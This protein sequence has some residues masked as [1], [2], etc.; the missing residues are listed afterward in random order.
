MECDGHP[1]I[2]LVCAFNPYSN[3]PLLKMTKDDCLKVLREKGGFRYPKK[4]LLQHSEWILIGVGHWG[5]HGYGLY[6]RSKEGEGG[7]EIGKPFMK[8]TLSTPDP[9]SKPNFSVPG[10]PVQHESVMLDH[11]TTDLELLAYAQVVD[12]LRAQG[13]L[14][15]HKKSFLHDVAAHFKIPEERHKSEVRRA[16]SSQ[17]L[18]TIAERLDGPGAWREWVLEGR[19]LIPLVERLEQRNVNTALADWVWTKPRL[20]KPR[21]KL[22]A[23]PVPAT[24]STQEK[25]STETE[26]IVAESSHSTPD[27]QTVLVEEG[28]TAGGL[29]G[30]TRPDT[31]DKT[32]KD[33]AKS[34]ETVDPGQET[35]DMEVEGA[36]E[37]GQEINAKTIEITPDSVSSTARSTEDMLVVEN[38]SPVRDEG[39]MAV[40]KG[41]R[42][43]GSSKRIRLSLTS[44]VTNQGFPSAPIHLSTDVLFHQNTIVGAYGSAHLDVHQSEPSSEL[45]LE[46]RTPLI[47]QERAVENPIA[48]S[49][50]AISE[51]ATS[52]NVFLVPMS[53]APSIIQRSHG[54]TVPLVDTPVSS[55]EVVYSSGPVHT[56]T[57]VPVSAGA[58]Q[59]RLVKPRTLVNPVMVP[60]TVGQLAGVRGLTGLQM[61]PQTSCINILTRPGQVVAR[62]SVLV[63]RSKTL[64]VVTKQIKQSL[65]MSDAGAVPLIMSTLLSV[66]C[67][68][69]S[70]DHIHPSFSQM[71]PDASTI[72]L[73]L[74]LCF[75]DPAGMKLVPVGGAPKILPKPSYVVTNAGTLSRPVT[76]TITVPSSTFLKTTSPTKGAT[77]TSQ[78][79]KAK[80]GP[81]KSNL[82]MVKKGASPTSITLSHKGKEVIGKVLLS[83]S[84]SSA[85]GKGPLTTLTVQKANVPL[86][87]KQSAGPG[88][89]GGKSKMVMV[90]LSQEQLSN[91][92]VLAEILQ[93]SGLLGEGVTVT[94]IKSSPAHHRGSAPQWVQVKQ[95]TGKV[96]TISSNSGTTAPTTTVI[97]L[98]EDDDNAAPY[99]SARI[100]AAPSESTVGDL[101]GDLDPQTGVYSA[102]EELATTV[103]CSTVRVLPSATVDI[104]SSALASADINLDSFQFMEDR[105]DQFPADEI[106][107]AT[108]DT[109]TQLLFSPPDGSEPQVLELSVED[110]LNTFLQPVTSDTTAVTVEP[111][112]MDTSEMHIEDFTSQNLQGQDVP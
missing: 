72:P 24:G 90:D 88:G 54:Y 83:K 50:T 32:S 68:C 39:I 87:G 41:T 34:D 56:T 38:P 84:K 102:P 112:H 111:S 29:K 22:S 37:R 8:I 80:E 74:S 107:G 44:Q 67:W 3:I 93:A 47:L 31:I 61:R 76:H 103:G 69:S 110:Q 35:I 20:R 104:F 43:E 105:G 25:D 15:P 9:D 71:L 78:V 5:E 59:L 99:K 13:K 85:L 18:H 57:S 4:A 48:T 40:L 21:S 98:A 66:R 64:P 94:S 73:E 96:S 53:P 11:G 79:P 101:S 91:N 109:A 70:S 62:S 92:A 46:S 6:M 14:T 58:P 75:F 52:Q 30:S 1:V 65:I 23:A 60:V 106:E 97:D 77:K 17:K 26:P 100:F 27:M 33:A 82:F 81:V 42:G 10:S 86:G 63:G 36:E 49:S 89:V 2:V 108:P 16:L 19:R 95:D 45:Y 51:H 55:T 28:A 7:W 12:V